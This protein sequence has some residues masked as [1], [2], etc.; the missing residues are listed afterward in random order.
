MLA[1]TKPVPALRRHP[2]SLLKDRG[3]A[4]SEKSHTNREVSHEPG[5]G[6]HI[7]DSDLGLGTEG[8]SHI[9]VWISKA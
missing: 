2:R 3:K 8:Y 4:I 5:E 9:G 1:G 6:V 7:Q